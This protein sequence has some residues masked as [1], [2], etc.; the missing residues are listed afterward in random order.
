MLTIRKE[1]VE[2][3][4]EFI[5]ESFK[6]N[7]IKRLR[8]KYPQETKEKNDQEMMSFINLGI[9][10][11]EIYNIIERSDISVFLEYMTN[12]GNDFDTNPKNEWATEVLK[13]KDL[14]GEEKISLMLNK[15]PL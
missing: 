14:P 5:E 13:I 10:K 2:R 7:S 3:L 8:S 6:T 4:G 12:Y 15:K 1:Q 9:E 11:A